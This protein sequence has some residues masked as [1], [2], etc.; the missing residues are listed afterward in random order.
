M[1]RLELDR[2]DVVLG[3]N[4]ILRAVSLDV[5]DRECVALLGPSGCGKTTTLRAIAGF[6]GTAAGGIRI[7]G[8]DITG[9]PPHRRNLGL[10]F[11]DYALFPHMNV[12][13]NIAY[14]L[15]MRG[16]D[17]AE[18]RSAVADVLR[19]VRL[20]GMADRYPAQM[21]GGQRQRVALARAL[22]IKPDILL[23]DEPLGAL[24]RKL[25]DHM[26]VELKRIQREVGITTIIVTHDQEEALSLS[27]RVAV[28]FDG[29]IR[30]IGA[31]SALY[32]RPETE[33]VMD[34]LGTANFFEGKVA[35]LAEG[36]ARIETADGLTLERSLDAAP[37]RAV[38]LG[39][40]P[41]HVGVSATG[42]GGANEVPAR[43]A[44]I[45]YKGSHVEI[46]CTV[47]GK[48]TLIARM[49]AL[50]D[51]LEI[52]AAVQVSLPPRHLTVVRPEGESA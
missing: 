27:D 10:V 9:L 1:A 42:A 47:A 52:G 37:G 40:R 45:V 32:E 28:M 2:I 41:E 38:K 23:L 3:G 14:G 51:K 44:E 19:L 29:T 30:E 22:V 13:K 16:R 26:Q 5:A 6:V 34:F 12:E 46:H 36:I 4:R 24:D 20:D 33:E 50:P 48:R 17:K 7:D 35:G 31:P 18:I 25:R 43:V 49:A 11:Q 21:S 39:I 15:V 8:R